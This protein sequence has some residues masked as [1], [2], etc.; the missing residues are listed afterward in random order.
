MEP[1]GLLCI[2]T[3]RGAP[4]TYPTEVEVASYRIA[5]EALSNVVRHAHASRAQIELTHRADGLRLV[6]K[7]DGVG[8]TAPDPLTGGAAS[9][10]AEV[11]QETGTGLGMLG[12]R[13]RALLIGAHLTVESAPGSGTRVTL[14]VPGAPAPSTRGASDLMTTLVK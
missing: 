11:D 3:E 2:F 5:Q 12:M 1:R 13:E 4:Q 7:D 8:F 14:D 9:L 10:L 6:V